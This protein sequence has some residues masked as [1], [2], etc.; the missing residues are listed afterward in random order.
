MSNC[1]KYT[2]LEFKTGEIS[3]IDTIGIYIYNLN[4]LNTQK[5]SL[6]EAF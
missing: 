3:N 1:T 4:K 6:L 5:E 2:K